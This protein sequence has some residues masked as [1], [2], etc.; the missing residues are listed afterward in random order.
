VAQRSQGPLTTVK[1][2]IKLEGPEALFKGLGAPL[3]TAAATS[4][5]TFIVRDKVAQAL[6]ERAERLGEFKEQFIAGCLAG[7]AQSV[8]RIPTDNIKTKLQVQF[9]KSTSE[10][11]QYKGSIDCARQ[12]W[13]QHGPRALAAGSAATFWRDIPGK[14]V[15]V[16]QLVALWGSSRRWRS[17]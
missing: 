2:I 1:K 9:G 4:A 6:C 17:F 14:S 11:L 8:V 3:G 13:K 7:G 5:V 12:I 16:S 10:A 15:C